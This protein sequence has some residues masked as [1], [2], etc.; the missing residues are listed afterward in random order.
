MAHTKCILVGVAVIAA[1]IVLAA[2]FID[3][4]IE[5]AIPKQIGNVF[6]PI[7]K[8]VAPNTYN[9]DYSDQ[10]LERQLAINAQLKDL[11]ESIDKQQAYNCTRHT[12][13]DYC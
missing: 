9:N 3:E 2:Y 7:V 4:P 10:V 6:N 5:E 13:L 8:A 12:G 11:Q 1:A